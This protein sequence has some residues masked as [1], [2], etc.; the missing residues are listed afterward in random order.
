MSRE[1]D[2][3]NFDT[4]F[5]GSESPMVIFKG[6]D[7]I[8]EMYNNKYHEIYQHRTFLGQSI[9][10]AVPELLDTPFPKILNTVYVTGEAISTREE[11]V[12]IM[13]QN[14]GKLEK[15]Y[16]DTTFS[17]IS[18][19]GE[20]FCILAAPR[21]VTERVEVRKRLEESLIE[22][23]EERELRER[24]VSALSHDLRSPLTVVTMCAF[25]LKREYEDKDTII[26]MSDR[27]MSSAARADRMIH[28]LLDVSRIKVGSGIPLSIQECS[29]DECVN[30]VIIDLEELYG[31]RFKVDNSTGS[32]IGFW[33]RMGIHRVLENLVSNA[34]KYGD[35]YSTI[36]IKLTSSISDVE[37]QVNNAGAP[38][39]AD[40]QLGLFNH[41]SRSKSAVKNSH[42]GWGIG[43]ALVKG[44]VEA[45]QG[46]ISLHSTQND[47]TTFTI[48]MPRDSREL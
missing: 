16:F 47:G 42:K 13:N 3:K 30:E 25:V 20:N 32:I 26:E 33:D 11:P 34:V 43:L 7:M 5:Y 21:E 23:Q 6:S 2:F 37:I 19:D 12:I 10:T 1:S 40:E 8:V 44:V 46:S 22:L 29:L 35:A 48:N 14:S 41:F 17:R 31:K 27:I 24:F 28:N 38:I 39:P 18:L 45:H 15:R 36:T 4:I 9:F